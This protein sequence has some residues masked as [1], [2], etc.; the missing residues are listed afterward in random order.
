MSALACTE[1]FSTFLQS[2]QVLVSRQFYTRDFGARRGREEKGMASG[3]EFGE[4]N[5]F[6]KGMDSGMDFGKGLD[7]RN[8]FREGLE[9]QECRECSSRQSGGSGALRG[10]FPAGSFPTEPTDTEFRGS[11][12]SGQGFD[13]IQLE[14]PGIPKKPPKLG[15]HG[16]SRLRFLLRDPGPGH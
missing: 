6:G 11:N 7:F 10:H 3:K 1:V 16:V 12:G 9:P 2:S 8:G 13:L 4:G 14:T 5:G 15:S